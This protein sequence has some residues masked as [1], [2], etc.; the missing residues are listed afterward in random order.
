MI[1]D[2]VITQCQLVII[3]LM[4]V[5]SGLTLGWLVWSDADGKDGDEK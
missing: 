3:V 2:I 5:T 1:A 4:S